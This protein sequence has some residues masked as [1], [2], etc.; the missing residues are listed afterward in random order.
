[1][2]VPTNQT[3]T[4]GATPFIPKV[5]N[6]EAW[7]VIWGRGEVSISAGAGAGEWRGWNWKGFQVSQ[8]EKDK[9]H[10]ISLVF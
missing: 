1:M 6:R 3:G 5:R 8:S 7:A 4:H 2:R 9:S 10:V